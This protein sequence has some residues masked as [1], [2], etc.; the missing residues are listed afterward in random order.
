[1]YRTHLNLSGAVDPA[2]VRRERVLV[3][4]EA[5]RSV[6]RG[7]ISH[8]LRVL[9]AESEREKRETKTNERAVSSRFDEK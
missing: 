1:M 3:R 2:R 4:G 6:S 7:F 9:W 5:A 8:Q